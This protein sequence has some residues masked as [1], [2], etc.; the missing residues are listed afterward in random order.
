MNVLGMANAYGCR[1]S[2]LLGL[3]SEYDAYC[4]DEACA[5][6]KMK[7]Q[8]GEKPQ[9]VDNKIKNR[10]FRSASEMYKALGV[11]NGNVEKR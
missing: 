1:P 10:H 3:E 7:L 6:I 5:Y 11:V 8:N 2:T 9:F 4:F